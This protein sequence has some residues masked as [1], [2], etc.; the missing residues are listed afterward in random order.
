[1]TGNMST[2]AWMWMLAWSAA[3]ASAAAATAPTPKGV[4]IDRAMPT[5]KL[6]PLLA[7]G[8]KDNRINI[9]IINRWM[10]GERNGYSRPEMR[11]EFLSDC[12]EVLR[13]F[14]PGDAKA[15]SP[16]AAYHGFFNVYALWWPSSP[17]WDPKD[18]NCLHWKHYNEIRDR[19]FLPWKRPG[20]GWVTH[21]AMLNS[22][23]GGGGAGLLR[24]KRVGDAMI[25]GND[26]AKLLHE[27]SHTAPGVSDEY[28]SFGMWGRGGEA[29]NTTND[30]RREGIKWRAWIDPATPVPTPYTPEYLNVV[31]AFEGGQHRLVNHYRPTARG[32]FMGAG[33]GDYSDHLC[34]VCVQRIILRSYEYVDAIDQATPAAETAAPAAGQKVRFAVRRVHPEPD[35]QK[36]RW[37]LDGKVLAE[38]RDE[39][40]LA[41]DAAGK[42]EVA[43]SLI[44]QTEL[45]RPDPPYAFRPQA[46]V[47]WAVV[48]GRIAA[49]VASPPVEPGTVATYKAGPAVA[50]GPAPAGARKTFVL[51]G[52]A[53]TKAGPHAVGVARPDKD[54]RYAWYAADLPAHIPPA[55]EGMYQGS[56]VPK[57]GRRVE[58]DAQVVA[59]LAGQTIGKDNDLGC[60]LSLRAWLGGPAVEPMALSL[61]LAPKDPKSPR[62]EMKV[63][64]KA[65]TTD[66][67]GTL[68]DG[69]LI[70]AGEG[71]EGGR[72][73]LAF[74]D[75]SGRADEPIARGA[76]FSPPR[77]G[78]YFLAAERPADGSVSGNR[79]GLAVTMGPPPPAREP[80]PPDR[81]AG[82]KLLLWLDAADVDGDGKHDATPPRRGALV[83]WKGKAGGVDFRDFVFYQPNR[84]NGLAVASWETIWLQALSQPVAGCQTMMMAYREH[85]LS[86]RGTAPWDALR[87]YAGRA[88]TAERLLCDEAAKKMQ[89]GAVYLDG[90]NVDPLATPNPMAF[91]VLTIELP[92]RLDRPIRN[93]DMYWEGAIG[94][95]LL[96]DGKL[97]AEERA[98]V[99]EYLR[100]KWVS[101]V[102]LDAK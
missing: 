95:M 69:K 84:Q 2:H 43:F 21:L 73:E 97:P 33:S 53:F 99:E 98:A 60:W 96:Y 30:F 19:L 58:A 75:C 34:C 65:G 66:W 26:V 79:V 12:R 8:P 83:G 6:V 59:N 68:A 92:A 89:G 74:V 17:A 28:T 13:G 94:E 23:G 80:V 4:D 5:L 40:E 54:L 51:S 37:T 46:E 3:T 64:G 9:V 62:G 22:S 32:C 93:T 42:H 56:F 41:L 91:C 55:P 44:D 88:A 48:D 86:G 16:Y 67:S 20:R 15:V 101:G 45:V 90:R 24:D 25:V 81:P 52:V 82:A 31:G 70:V 100:R 61:S 27:F 7:S 72:F 76:E 47:R 38:G 39:I 87:P 78:N 1:M 57:A 85:P 29:A 63:S 35:T 14:A 36:T 71:N 77:P 50:T 10:K 102:H 18:P 49:P 11:E